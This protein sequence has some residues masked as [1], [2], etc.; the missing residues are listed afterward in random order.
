MASLMEE[1]MNTLEL[2][3]VEYNKLLE[4]AKK[5]TPVIVSGD[6]EQ[7]RKVTDEEQSVA[8]TII[9][10]DLK[11][12]QITRDIADVINK[13]VESLKLSVLIEILKKQPEESRRL[14]DIRDRLK[15]VVDSV[16]MINDQ[17]KELIQHSLE[18]VEFDL[19]LIKSMRQA[20][21]TNNYGRGAVNSGSILGGTRGGFDAKQ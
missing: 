13:D 5:K 19:N 16:K 12:E 18:M 21:E 6:M 15:T 10:L 11:R 7:L 1:L 3:I 8:D 14:A 20:P 9:N 2:E 17:N 4:L